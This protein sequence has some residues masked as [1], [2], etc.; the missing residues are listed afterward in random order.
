M[1]WET[2]KTMKIPCL[3]RNGEIIQ[4][5]LSDDWNRFEETE[6]VIKCEKCSKK[7]KIVSE[8]HNPKPHHEY[9]VYYCVDKETGEKTKIDL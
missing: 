7:Y 5:I 4:E 6:P 1:S 2:F 8:F 3:C 9:T